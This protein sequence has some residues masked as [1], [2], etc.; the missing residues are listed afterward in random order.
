MHLREAEV[1]NEFKSRA[2]VIRKAGVEV[3]TGEDR[4][5]QQTLAGAIS[6]GPL[7][8]LDPET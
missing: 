5:V 4:E 6:T 8:V 2:I 3:Q 1:G 7:G